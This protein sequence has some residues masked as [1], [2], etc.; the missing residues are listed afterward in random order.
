L[1]DLDLIGSLEEDLGGFLETVHDA[2]SERNRELGEELAAAV[3]ILN[4]AG[5]TPLLL[6]GA[7]RLVDGL[8]PDQGWRMLR[9]L[10]LLVPDARFA[11][12]ARALRSAGYILA[13]EGAHNMAGRRPGGLG[14]ID[15]HSE[16]FWRWR[17]AQLLRADE[18]LDHS[19]PATFNGLAIR[20]PSL[21]HQ[22]VH[23]IGHS[24]IKHHDHALGR[25]SWRDRLEAAALIRWA[26]KGVDWEA[27]FARFAV[28]GFR[29][30]LLVFLLSL[31]DG[32]LCPVP[33]PGVID[34]LTMLQQRR[35]ASQAR[36]AFL[37]RVG[38]WAGWSASK[39]RWQIVDRDEG[40]PRIITSLRRLF[41][42]R[43]AGRRIARAFIDEVPPRW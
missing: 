16:L 42:E 27:V 32:F 23:L 34:P 31:G 36:S 41:L 13:A 22:I 20:L 5:I 7:I 38:L 24:Q 25:I 14:D 17:D 9:D 29:R 6:K 43:G 39:L 3:S 18:M 19:R 26:P 11:D 8:Y 21:E 37:A 28:T 10:D 40:R 12:A 15:L 2:N 30:P 33:A 4:Q 35:I 1:R